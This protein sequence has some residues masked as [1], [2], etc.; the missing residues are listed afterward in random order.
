MKS[1]DREKRLET[2]HGG[3]CN[4]L[5]AFCMIAFLHFQLTAA[6]Q[7]ST[8]ARS[9]AIDA[10]DQAQRPRSA[11]ITRPEQKKTEHDNSDMFAATNAQAASPV[12]KS[13]PDNGE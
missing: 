8:Q 13:Q 7:S 6:S 11:S 1:N 3:K 5:A 4:R 2:S 10:I 9:E 12:F